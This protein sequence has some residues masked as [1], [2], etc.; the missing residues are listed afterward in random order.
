[1]EELTFKGV[2]IHCDPSYI[3]LHFHLSMQDSESIP[4]QC[5]NMKN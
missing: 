5:D 2:I 3:L 1:M 4:A